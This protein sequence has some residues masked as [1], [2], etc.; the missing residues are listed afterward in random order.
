MLGVIMPPV[1]LD[2]F[3]AQEMNKK[4]TLRRENEGIKSRYCSDSEMSLGMYP[5]T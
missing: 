2:E 3:T 1:L 4:N 5:T